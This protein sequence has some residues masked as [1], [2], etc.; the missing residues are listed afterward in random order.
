MNTKNTLAVV[1]VIEKQCPA[2]VKAMKEL[3]IKDIKRP[4]QKLC[5]RSNGSILYASQNSY[6]VLSNFPLSSVWEEI[7]TNIPFVIDVMNAISGVE[8]SS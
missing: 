8:T 5:S 1:E 3:F 7:E 2:I 4:C 6:N